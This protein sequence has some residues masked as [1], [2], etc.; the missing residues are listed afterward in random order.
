MAETGGLI[1]ADASLRGARVMI[2]RGGSWG[3]RVS[4]QVRD[5]G[6]E[7]VVHP[8]IAVVPAETPAL[9]EAIGRWNRGTYDWVVLTSANAVEAILA[10]AGACPGRAN[11]LGAGSKTPTRIAVVGPGTATAARAVG[12][13][14]D[15]MPERDFSTEG[16]MVAL[17]VELGAEATA[18]R[19]RFLLPLSN[20]SDD[21]LQTWLEAA[22]HHVDRVTAYETV[23]VD[24]D[25]RSRTAFATAV[26]ESDVILVTS[27]S[28]ARALAANLDAFDA[29]VLPTIAAIGEPTA[30]ALRG[31]GL[32][33]Q[34][35]AGSQTI[36][37]LLAAVAAQTNEP[38]QQK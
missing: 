30:A 31:V 36:D 13:G 27:G 29:A 7:P 38:H 15:V 19:Q 17:G 16:L 21:R 2:L 3:E 4:R 20:L 24:Q 34:L 10:V 9:R 22:G 8:L 33:P 6:G 32:I 14:V 26:A 18:E 25:A 37:G 5:R 23:Q 12:L 35:V 1:P 11:A 28:A